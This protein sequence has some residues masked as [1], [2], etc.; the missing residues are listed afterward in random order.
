MLELKN[1][2]AAVIENPDAVDNNEECSFVVKSSRDW[3]EG[4]MYENGNSK[5]KDIDEYDISTEALDSI[6]H[7][8]INTPE[9][10][11]EVLAEY[12]KYISKSTSPLSY[13]FRATSVADRDQWIK[14]IN[15]AIQAQRN[16]QAE[17][18]FQARSLLH[19]I[20][21]RARV[22]YLSV[23]FQMGT[24]LLVALNFFF[25]VSAGMQ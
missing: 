22:V 13:H 23:P 5:T 15:L 17:S 18:A 6:M 2:V 11:D 8:S 25:T 12:S 20:Q 1:V 3:N 7:D 14:A 10:S 16:A 4:D 9:F 21:S 19:Q 24:A